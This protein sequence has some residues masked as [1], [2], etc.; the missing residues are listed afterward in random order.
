V[1]RN[2]DLDI[3]E[4]YLRGQARLG[5]AEF[6][7]GPQPSDVILVSFPK[8][9]S[10]WMSYLIHL[11][12]SGGD[13]QFR[14]IKDEVIDITPGHWDP[15]V[16]PFLL[17]QRFSPRTYKTHGSRRL[18][19]SGAKY[20]YIA[21]HPRDSLYSLYH[22]V[23]DLFAIPQLI[24]IE[25]F[26][27]HYYV[28][29]FGTGHDIG[30]VWN[31]LLGWHPARN[32]ENILWIHYED[33][34]EDLSTCL[35][36]IAKFMGTD[37]GSQHIHLVLERSSI[38]SMRKIAAQL[39]PSQHNRVGRVVLGFGPG[40]NRYASDMKFGKMRRGVQGDGQRH[41]PQSIRNALDEEWTTRITPKLGYESYEAMR[42]ECS[43]LGDGG[44]R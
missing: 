23:H 38:E 13:Q 17:P 8:S 14:D 2:T 30:N 40:M 9:G 19:P 25:D 41:L 3:M 12:R 16:N 44:L 42:G 29:R 35:R 39:N 26:Y 36:A 32:D 7:P 37:S 21:R 18:C 31:H 5:Y 27:R 10:T 6:E 24:P 34:L 4:A 28:E 22:F 11:L 1:S 15:A 33:L 43:I 20:I